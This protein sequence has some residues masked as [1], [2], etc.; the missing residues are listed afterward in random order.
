MCKGA[1]DSRSPVAESEAGY[2]DRGHHFVLR[3]DIAAAIHGE[4]K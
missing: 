3:Q 4:F 2:G 1:V